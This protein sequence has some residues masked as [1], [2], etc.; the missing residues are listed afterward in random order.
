MKKL[1]ISL[2]CGLLC[3]GTLG[4][5]PSDSEENKINRLR[6]TQQEGRGLSKGEKELLREAQ[7]E[8]EQTQIDD[9]GEQ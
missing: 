6:E 4:C 2:L 8:A 3:I 7:E 1:V 5:G 9:R